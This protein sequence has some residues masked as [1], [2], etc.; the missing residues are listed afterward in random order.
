LPSSSRVPNFVGRELIWFGLRDVGIWRPVWRKRL[1]F[2][3]CT[4]NPSAKEVGGLEVFL[5]EPAQN[6]ELH[7]RS[8]SKIKNL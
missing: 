1:L 6:F 2:V 4:H 8:E 5:F 7:S 3:Q